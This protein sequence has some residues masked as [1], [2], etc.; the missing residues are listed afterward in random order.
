MLT[1][2]LGIYLP[3][4]VEV[5]I[6]ANTFFSL[7]IPI[8][9]I[10]LGMMNIDQQEVGLKKMG[11]EYGSAA[12]NFF[13]QA[14]G[15]IILGLVHI[16]A[17]PIQNCESKKKGSRWW[18][19]F[20]RLGKGIWKMLTFTVYLRILLQSSQML[21]VLT[22]SE[23]FEADFSQ[24]E[25]V[26]SFGISIWMVAFLIIFFL[27]GSYLL[28]Q[29]TQK[30][31]ELSNSRVEE[32]FAGFKKKK[33]CMSYNLI[34]LLRRGIMVVWIVWFKGIDTT[35][36]L[37]GASLIQFI[38]LSTI[39]VIRPFQKTKDNIIEIANE[40]VFFVLLSGLVNFQEESKWG[41]HS[42]DAYCYLIMFP[43]FFVCFASI[44]K[45]DSL[46]VWLFHRRNFD[47]YDQVHLQEVRKKTNCPWRDNL[48]GKN[49]IN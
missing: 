20:R 40:A 9:F 6:T 1:L 24:L 38:Q 41:N 4:K 47:K 28:Y 36:Y 15:I 21:L 11:I 25:L 35:Y 29:R 22:V 8:D 33:L 16:F 39:I 26:I 5:L 18:N 42:T 17:I 44:C 13:G 37:I 19:C 48:C 49:Q 31:I 10:D 32:L 23:I 27:F 2:L 30:A 34:L 46:K 14:I 7:V 12:R 3:M 45:L 43:G